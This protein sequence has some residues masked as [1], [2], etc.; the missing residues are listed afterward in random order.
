MG[1][2]AG[3][4]PAEKGAPEGTPPSPSDTGFI[5][6]SQRSIR[7]GLRYRESGPASLPVGSFRLL[8]RP[9]SR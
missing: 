5:G 6:G 1:I 2:G 3:F 7:E 9:C 8:E 4:E